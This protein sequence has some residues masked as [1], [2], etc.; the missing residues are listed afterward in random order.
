M[1]QTS[2]AHA[3]QFGDLFVAFDLQESFRN[4]GIGRDYLL[5]DSADFLFL[6][7]YQVLT[8]PELFLRQQ[9]VLVQ[10]FR[11]SQ[12]LKKSGSSPANRDRHVSP[13]ALSVP[14]SN[15]ART[16]HPIQ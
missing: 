1:H 16:K 3:A 13:S 2:F 7:S 14:T 5:L 9:A 15:S 8:F 6:N 11:L 4:L 12:A 10:L